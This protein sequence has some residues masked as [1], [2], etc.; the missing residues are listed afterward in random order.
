MISLEWIWALVFLPLPWLY[1]YL[2][3][4]ARHAEQ[5]VLRVPFIQDFNRASTRRLVISRN[6]WLLWLGLL[7]WVCLVLAAAR[8][9][10]IGDPI[11]LPVSG[12]DIMLAVDLSG[13]MKTPDFVLGNR[14]PVDR[15]T[16]TKAV[17]GEFI[18]RRTGDRIGLILFGRQAYVQTP[19]TFDRETVG[20]LL[21]ESVIGLAGR[22]TAIGDAIGLAVKRFREM[23]AEVQEPVTP[24]TSAPAK[25]HKPILILLT[26]GANT[27]GEVEPV[28]AAKYAAEEGLK[29]YT[30]GIGA[31]EMIVPSIFGYRRENPSLDLDEETLTAI[32]K[33]TGG[34]YF[35]ARDTQ[36]LEKIYKILD[37]LEPVARET[38]SFRPKSSLY[39]WPLTL[40]LCLGGLILLIKALKR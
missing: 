17:A 8:P 33:T 32:A 26:D 10:W 6:R 2:L 20:K 19:L 27:A 4:V 16:A 13:S 14:E 28:Q 24:A 15:L 7:G 5:S 36:E 37:E 3:P 18:K 9:Q 35:R 22:E 11:E 12:R 23:P 30:I 29:I 21:N 39:M 25:K 1:R 34:K 38:K 40:A 31:D